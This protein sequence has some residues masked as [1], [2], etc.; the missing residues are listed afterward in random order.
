MSEQIAGIIE[1]VTYHDEDSGYTVLK[2][3][4]Q[5]RQPDAEARDGT[6]TVVGNM[7][8]LSKGE[9]AHFA[10][11]WV[12]S[13]RYGRQFRAR[14]ASPRPPHTARGI[15]NFLSSG[16]V[17]GIGPRTAEKIVNHLGEQT[18]TIIDTE[19]ERIHNVPGLKKEL[20]ENLV[21]AW[22]Q[23]RAMRDTLIYLQG[24]GISAK[25]A[26]RIWKEYAGDTQRIL[27]NNPYKL[28]DDVFQVG[29]RKADHIAMNIGLQ[30][31]DPH[32]LQAG[33]HFALNELA[34]AGHSYAPR[35]QL[36][37]KA[38][39]L[40]DVDNA[41]ALET[42][43]Q[44]QLHTELLIAEVLP[45][46][47]EQ[48]PIHAV[49]LPRFFC[50]EQAASQQLQA[51]A[52]SSSPLM[53]AHKNKNWQRF[54]HELS[55]RNHMSLSAQQQ[56]AV[57]TAL[58]QKVTVLTGGP[59]TGKTTTLQMLIHALKAGGMSFQLAS[60]TGRAAKRLSEATGEDARTIHR[61]LGYSPQAGGF[62]YDAENPLSTDI[63]V[64]DEASMLDLLLFH[65]LLQALPIEAHLL[66]VGDVDQLPS[67]GAGNVLR[68]VI[69]S[70]VA[71]VIRLEQIFR[72]DSQSQIVGN[73]HRINQGLPPITDNRGSDFFFFHVQEPDAAADMLVDIVQRRIPERW[74]FDPLE[75]IQ[76]LA[77]MNR[78][79]TGVHRL[80]HLLQE[81]LNGSGNVARLVLRN[82]EFRVG[83]KIMQ[84][85]NNYDKEVF[86]GDIGFI[87]RIDPIDQALTV[88]M[89]G[90]L[91]SYEAS[92][93]EDL[94]LAYCISTHRSQGSEYPVVVM[95]I[96]TQH[97]L[98]LQ[99]NLL[100][101]AIT[102][103]KR[104]VV[105]VGTRQALHIAVANNN[106]AARYSGLLARLRLDIAAGHLCD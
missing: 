55:Q 97:Y 36:L 5:E 29:F 86:N 11:E 69:G 81:R 88:Q 90:R 39:E 2:I 44:A 3:M 25:I 91:H 4:P 6:V 82:R 67:V 54:L 59:G 45:G 77:P 102:R 37:E 34:R 1:R 9:S 61:L 13:P 99:R 32:R 60:P 50:A 76:V 106:I 53:R 26:R 14:Q 57:R 73:A 22:A 48:E 94:R 95:P 89:G 17:K 28:A 100:Y 38:Q 21:T 51:I 19:P 70:G 84:T 30:A 46:S 56:G 65:S 104:L 101:T 43:L 16:I 63:L 33:L 96:L 8:T 78:G 87:T 40:L 62:A 103:A 49:Y 92:E 42:A 15:I 68:D 93:L 10:G 31:S 7:P 105:L 47:P 35:A 83:D 12:D 80:N 79:I 98:M 74:A 58:T 27:E 75:D 20:A 18:I 52:T 85:R 66:L 71:K 64:I 41:A 23:N 24:I 72:Q